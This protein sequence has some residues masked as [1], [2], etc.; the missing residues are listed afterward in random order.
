MKSGIHVMESKNVMFKNE[1]NKTLTMQNFMSKSNNYTDTS[2]KQNF[3][4]VS[5]IGKDL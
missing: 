4:K 2:S 5:G 1:P 3:K